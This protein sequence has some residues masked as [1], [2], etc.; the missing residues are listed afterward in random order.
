MRKIIYFLITIILTS[1]CFA[2]VTLKNCKLSNVSNKNNYLL[3]NYK[4]GLIVA[5]NPRLVIATARDYNSFAYT[6]TSDGA[7]GI[8]QYKNGYADTDSIN[9]FLSGTTGRVINMYNQVNY[10]N[11]ITQDNVPLRPYV[12]TNIG[13]WTSTTSINTYYTG[14]LWNF[15]PDSPEIRFT[16][17]MTLIFM[18]K[19][20]VD[21]T[22]AEFL[23]SKHIEN[24]SGYEVHLNAASS[25]YS[26]IRYLIHRLGAFD[27]LDV[28][29]PAFY[30][31]TG[32]KTQLAFVFDNG[33]MRIYVNGVKYPFET[34]CPVTSIPVDSTPLYFGIR[35]GAIYPIQQLHLYSFYAWA[36]V[37][38]DAEILDIY[39]KEKL[40][41]D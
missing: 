33:I 36:R 22:T 32:E 1:F 34:I 16:N 14:G 3:N 40:L 15:I 25:G 6:R 4:D 5:T 10:L 20:D 37:L 38:T 21:A 13:V 29:T 26:T 31:K 27:A 35:N 39:Q 28:I 11:I 12:N 17:A 18:I 19:K 9:T 7:V 30:I 24:V 2:G 23:F 41:G 8:A